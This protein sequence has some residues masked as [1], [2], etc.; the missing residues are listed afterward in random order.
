M[1]FLSG[2]TYELHRYGYKSGTYG[3]PGSLMTDL[4]RKVR[5][6]GFHS[7]DD[8]WFAHWNGLR[9]TTD[10]SSYPGFP[11]ADW[12]RRQRVHQ[13]S[14]N[15]YQGW[16]RVGLSIDADWVDGAVAGT[17]VKVVKVVKRAATRSQ[18]AVVKALYAD[19]LLRPADAKGLASW[20][21]FL[22]AG[23]RQSALITSLTRSGEYVQLRV[24]QA[25]EKVLGHAPNTAALTEWST[26]VRARKVSVDNV[27]PRLYTSPEFAIRSG[28]TNAGYAVHL[29][30]SILGRKPSRAAVTV[31]VGR[32]NHYGRVWA[33]R[34]LWYSP[35]AASDRV[36]GYFKLFLKRAVDPGGRA[37]WT[38]VLLAHGEGAV[39]T[40]LAGS[41]EYRLLALKR[42]R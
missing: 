33:V 3:S 20:S 1:T 6:A 31:W 27:Q 7:P 12:S 23:G 24:R 11:N 26:A 34:R 16:G 14:G 18:V 9:N 10:Q 36:N 42:Y 37:A 19:L 38:R 2:W 17:P 25:Y 39:R 40:G 21:A 13:Y 28:G 8:V 30:T 41:G 22:A 4:S 35:E 15:L 5:T 29:Y 32:I